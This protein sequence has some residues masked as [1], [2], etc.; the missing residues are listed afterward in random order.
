MALINSRFD[1]VKMSGD[2]LPTAST[3]QMTASCKFALNLLT[4]IISFGKLTILITY[5]VFGYVCACED[6]L[7]YGGGMILVRFALQ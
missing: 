3:G 4:V 5:S 1:D 7:S 2:M 6:R